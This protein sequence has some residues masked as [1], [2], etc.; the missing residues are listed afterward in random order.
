MQVNVKYELDKYLEKD[1]EENKKG[2]DIMKWWKDNATR[3]SI[4]PHM[5]RDVVA[6]RIS[7]VV[8]ESAF[9]AGGR[10]LDDFRASLTPTMV[11]RL[12]C[13]DDWLRYI[14]VE[15]H[16][17]QLAKL[18]EGNYIVLNCQSFVMLI[19]NHTHQIVSTN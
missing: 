7:T 1:N 9:G 16:T 6:I 2:F 17:Q 18:E 10:T 13:A 12:I 15:E 3:L 4:L 8:S 11:E 19:M 14:N 5:A